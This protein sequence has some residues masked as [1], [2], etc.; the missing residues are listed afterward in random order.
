ML[1]SLLRDRLLI[2][3]FLLAIAIRLFS[4][5][6]DWVEKYYTYAFYP[7]FSTLFR[8]LLGWIPFSVGDILYV[9]A[10]IYLISKVW[11][12]LRILVKRKVKEY[13]SWILFRKF[14]KLVLW[15]YVIFNLAWGLNFDRA[16]IAGQL[17]LD[18][19]P[20]TIDELYQLTKIL[21]TRVNEYAAVV[22]S[23]KRDRLNSN[24][25]LF[26]QGIRDFNKASEQYSFLQYQFPSIK[27]SLYGASGKYFGY[28]GYYNPFTGEAQLKT[29]MPVFMK[30]FVLNHEIAHQI[31]YARENEASFVSWL[32][33]KNSESPEVRYSIYYELF[34]DA[35]YQF[36]KTKNM[37]HSL[38][39]FRELHP[40]VLTDKKTEM[41]YLDRTKNMVAPFMSTAYDKYLKLNNQPKGKA[42]YD[43][44]IAWLVAYMRKYGEEGI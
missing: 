2:F 13:L 30:S 37:M 24:D 15:I 41:G 8:F 23:A 1:K 35:F 19:K 10:L 22:D 6:E 39:L 44:V 11:K 33:G 16:G 3:L 7:F 36:W 43:E 34:Y 12:F 26:E 9:A 18:V 31:G 32:V 17:G 4:M 21:H 29:S 25:S 27:P 14:L 20:Y 5:N 40:R 38:A 42:T 28:T